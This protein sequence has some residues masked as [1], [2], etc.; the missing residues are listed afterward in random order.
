M[1]PY[2]VSEVTGLRERLATRITDEGFIPSMRPYVF[3]EVTGRRERLTTR[4]ANI[5][6]LP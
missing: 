4:H 6:L 3:S 2:V 1:R 5:W